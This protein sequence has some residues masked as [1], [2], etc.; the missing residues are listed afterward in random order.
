MN[1]LTLI[2]AIILQLLAFII[3]IYTNKVIQHFRNK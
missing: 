1:K 2:Y 3:L